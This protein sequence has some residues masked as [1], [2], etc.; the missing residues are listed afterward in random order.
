V[1]RTSAQSSPSRSD[2]ATSRSTGSN[3]V[4]VTTCTG[5]H[6]DETAEPASV[7]SS[8]VHDSAAAPAPATRNTPTTSAA[9]TMTGRRSGRPR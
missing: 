5:A 7:S 3:D 9:S 4:D 8:P 2:A 1:I 6:D